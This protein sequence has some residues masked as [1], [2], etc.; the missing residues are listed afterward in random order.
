MR[1]GLHRIVLGSVALIAAA[2][3]AVYLSGGAELISSY[4]APDG[5][6]KVE[7]VGPTRWQQLIAGNADMPGVARF[8]D[9]N[10]VVVATSPMLEL[11]GEGQVYWQADSV[12]VGSSAIYDRRARRWT[13]TQ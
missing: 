5:R 9:A 10:G 13:V 7:L 12:Q 8:V 2:G 1:R 4:A 6:E 11:S 3:G